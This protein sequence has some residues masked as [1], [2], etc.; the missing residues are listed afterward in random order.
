MK[1]IVREG[2]NHKVG[3][4]LVENKEFFKGKIDVIWVNSSKEAQLRKELRIRNLPILIQNNQ[5]IPEEDIISF[6]IDSMEQLDNKKDDYDSWLDAE[7]QNMRNKVKNNKSLDDEE[8][9]IPD[10]NKKLANFAK[11]KECI[12]P[13]KPS[14]NN[15]KK[16]EIDMDK[17]KSA[18]ADNHTQPSTITDEELEREEF[19]E[20][21]SKF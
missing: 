8:E 3:K 2:S 15:Q 20:M 12:K 16:G 5:I 17:F 11:M 4:F 9:E 6:L 19:L 14:N 13:P 10:Y 21:M 1:L 7:V 18:I